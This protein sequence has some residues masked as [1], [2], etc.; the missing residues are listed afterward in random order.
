MRR[1]EEVPDFDLHS[2][3]EDLADLLTKPLAR[4]PFE[5]L[6]TELGLTAPPTAIDSSGGVKVVVS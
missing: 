1:G 6:R 2:L 4:E 3:A 5:R